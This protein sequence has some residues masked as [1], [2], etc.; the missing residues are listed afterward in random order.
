MFYKMKNDLT[1]GTWQDDIRCSI[2]NILLCTSDVPQ[3]PPL[4]PFHYLINVCF[5]RASALLR[6]S[7]SPTIFP[8]S[9]CLT[10]PPLYCPWYPPLPIIYHHHWL[11]VNYF[12]I[13]FLWSLSCLPTSF[14]DGMGFIALL[15][16]L[17]S[18]PSPITSFLTPLLHTVSNWPT[19]IS[20][21][22]ILRAGHCWLIAMSPHCLCQS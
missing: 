22:L 19:I 15:P 3:P 6:S 12:I 4:S 11:I 17:V 1:T 9:P 13:S 20:L 16:H 2:I 21:L 7:P 8:L 5:I 10:C 14:V 18:S